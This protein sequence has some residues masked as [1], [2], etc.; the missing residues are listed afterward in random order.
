[1][2][3]GEPGI[4]PLMVTWFDYPTKLATAAPKLTGLFTVT[5][6][7]RQVITLPLVTNYVSVFWEK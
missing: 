5:T 7:N 1:M 3:P 4:E 2:Y 6:K